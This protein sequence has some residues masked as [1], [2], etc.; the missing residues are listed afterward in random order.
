MSATKKQK[1]N[2]ANSDETSDDATNLD[3]WFASNAPETPIDDLMKQAKEFLEKQHEAGRK[4][5]LVT[6][7]CSIIIQAIAF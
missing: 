6:V 1:T 5:V 7:S 3:A 2:H 4:V